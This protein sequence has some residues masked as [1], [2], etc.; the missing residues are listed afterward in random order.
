MSET[1]FSG[2]NKI[3]GSQK[4]FGG[5]APHDCGS[6]VTPTSGGNWS[7]K[8]FLKIFKQTLL[9]LQQRSWRSTLW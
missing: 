7:K 1:H 5:N 8:D 3:C 4:I 2:H 9:A 6:G